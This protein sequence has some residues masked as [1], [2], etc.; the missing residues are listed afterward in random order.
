ML[1]QMPSK[2][3]VIAL[4]AATLAVVAAIIILL[5]NKEEAY[6]SIMV[7]DMEGSAVIERADIGTFDAAENLYLE[8]GDRVSVDTDSLMRMKLDSDK[9]ITAESDTIFSL[10]AQGDGQNSK[11]RINLEQGAIT[12]EIQNP[13]SQ[14]STYETATPNSVMAVR[15]TIYRVELYNGEE[16]G[17]DMRLCCFEGTVATMPILPDGTVGEEVLVRAGS[18]LTVYSDGT[19]SEIEN[20]NYETLPMQALQTLSAITDSGAEIAG[21]TGEE[22]ARMVSS[23]EQEYA[24][25][26]QDSEPSEEAGDA[27]KSVT[28]PAAAEKSVQDENNVSTVNEGKNNNTARANQSTVENKKTAGNGTQQRPENNTPAA[29]NPSNVSGTANK[30]SVTDDWNADDQNA[31]GQDYNDNNEGGDTS[32]DDDQEEPAKPSKPATYTV[33]F[34]YDG[35]V[36]ATQTVIKGAKASEPVLK[37]DM[38]GKWDFDFDTPITSNVAI[39]WK[40]KLEISD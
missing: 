34:Q 39:E 15:G 14:G 10:E 7:Y 8:S 38:T 30:N 19:V 31:D 1:K 11:T 26:D 32:G 24:A 23:H 25:A 18:E 28:N 36:F 13:L 12:N 16:G 22:I 5:L 35:Q 6:R 40:A 37:P 4:S 17:Q 9:Y 29:A 2:K 20:I 3:I 27:R 33:T 21:I